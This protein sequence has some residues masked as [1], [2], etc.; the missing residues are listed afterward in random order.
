MRLAFI[1]ES[2]NGYAKI[3]YLYYSYL[4][5][6]RIRQQFMPVDVVI[7]RQ[8]ATDY[9]SLHIDHIVANSPY[10]YIGASQFCGAQSA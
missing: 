10:K 1:S 3:I 9:I 7:L 6:L 8:G 2:A 5:D 4:K